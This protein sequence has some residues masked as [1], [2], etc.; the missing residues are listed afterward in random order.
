MSCGVG[1][2]CG[3]DLAL[4]WLWYRPAAVALIRPLT[5]ELPYAA[6]V[7]PKSKSK[8]NKK[9]LLKYSWS[10]NNMGLNCVDLLIYGFSI[11]NTTVPC[12]PQLVESTDTGESWIGKAGCKLIWVFLTSWRAGT[13]NACVQGATVYFHVTHFFLLCLLKGL[14]WRFFHKGIEKYIGGGNGKIL[15]VH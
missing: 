14:R 13:P 8:T 5:W 10:L 3:L 11:A 1:H 7:A 12:D 6:P 9:R 15:E 4:L 2:R